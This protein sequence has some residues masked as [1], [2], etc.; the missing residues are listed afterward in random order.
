MQDFW[1]SVYLEF[2]DENLLLSY[3]QYMQRVYTPQT[4]QLNFDVVDECLPI[5]VSFSMK[6][7]RKSNF[8]HS[9]LYLVHQTLRQISTLAYPVWYLKT[10]NGP[11]RRGMEYWT[12]NAYSLPRMKMKILI[13]RV[14]TNMWPSNTC[15][16]CWTNREPLYMQPLSAIW[17]RQ[18]WYE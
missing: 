5:S 10:K 1:R 2:I 15:M 3:K 9:T 4:R 8:A 18:H 14:K 11:I 6:V 7:F 13:L 12:S 16:F 17:T